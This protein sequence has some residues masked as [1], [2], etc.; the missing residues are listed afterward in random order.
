MELWV[1]GTKKQVRLYELCD[2][3]AKV[4]NGDRENQNRT[5]FTKK[6][7]TF[8]NSRSQNLRPDV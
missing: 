3:R 1:V 8:A 2:F 5:R 7:T 6:N 4:R